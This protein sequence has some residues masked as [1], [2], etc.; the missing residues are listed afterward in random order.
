MARLAKSPINCSVFS[1]VRFPHTMEITARLSTSR[2]T[3][4]HWEPQLG[5]SSSVQFLS[6]FPHKVPLLVRLGF[7]D[8][9]ISN[10]LIVQSFGMVACNSCQ[11]T[12][13]P[14]TH[15]HQ[16]A[17]LPLPT[18]L[19]QMMKNRDNLLFGKPAAGQGRMSTFGE[20]CST[21]R[22]FEQPNSI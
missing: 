4:S 20:S 16:S 11:P 18:A 10:Q 5:F 3:L 6:F 19:G 22:T 12:D 21:D 9:D 14:P 8:D 15:F 2:T 13:G 17:N 1:F 7:A